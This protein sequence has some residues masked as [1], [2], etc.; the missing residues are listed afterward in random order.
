MRTLPT[1]LIAFIAIAYVSILFFIAFRGDKKNTSGFFARHR[2]VV[3]SLSLA[4]YCSSWTFFGAVGSA[5]RSGWDFFAIYLGPILVFVLGYKIIQRIIII[6]KQY[7]ITAISD[8]LS[9]RYGKSRS[10]AVLVTFIAVIGSLPYISLQLHAISMSFTTLTTPAN[11]A[12][13]YRTAD[14]LWSDTAFYGALILALFSILFGT[15]HLSAT[16][17]HRGMMNAIAFESIVKLVAMLLVGLYATQLLFSQFDWNQIMRQPFELT[18]VTTESSRFSLSDFATKLLLSMSAIMLLPRQFQVTVVE[19]EDHRQMDSARWL[20]PLYL[21]LIS[22]VVVPIALA[23]LMLLPSGSN[24]DF[25][26]LSLPQQ[27]SEFSLAM[28]AFVGGISAG[29]GMVIVASISLSTMVCNDVVMPLLIRS[30]FID[31]QQR[32]DLSQI[33]LRIRR[34]TIVLLML[35]S[36]GYFRLSGNNQQL[37]NMGLLSFAAI[38]Q[39]APAMIAALYWQRANQRGVLLGLGIGFIAWAYTLLMPNFVSPATLDAAFPNINWLHPHHLFNIQFS[40]SL[41]HGVVWS[42]LLNT[43][44]MVFGS[45]RYAPSMLDKI[46]ASIFTHTYVEPEALGQTANFAVNATVANAKILCVSIIG[47]ASTDQLFD[48]YARQRNKELKDYDIVDK[49][50]IEAIERA[51]AGVIGASSARHIITTQLLGEDVSAEDLFVMMDETSQAL[52]F[53]QDI[54]QASFENISQGISVVDKNLKLV[55]WN[56]R[57]QAMFEYPD[58]LLKIGTPIEKLIGYNAERGDCGPGEIKALIERRLKH[59]RNSGGYSSERKRRGAYIKINGNPIPGGGFVTSFTDITE[60]KNI[61]QALR[62]S[63]SRIRLYTDNLPLMLCYIGRDEKVH[64]SNKAYNQFIGKTHSEIQN[65]SVHALFDH[66]QFKD[67]EGHI[68]YALE[69]NLTEFHCSRE[70][71]EGQIT[72]YQVNYIPQISGQGEADGF[73][74]IYQ[75]I[76]QSVEASDLLKK[77]NEQLEDRVTERT[78]DLEHLNRQL[79]SLTRSKTRFLAAASHDLLQP[80]N[81]ARLFTNSLIDQPDSQNQRDVNLLHKIDSSLVGADKLLRALLDI[82]RLDTGTLSPEISHFAIADLMEDLRTELAPLAARKGLA[83]KFRFSSALVSSDKTLLRSIIQNLVSNAIRYTSSGRI[84]IACRTKGNRLQIQVF[85]T[86]TGIS[87]E[88]LPFIFDEFHR[89]Q[90]PADS[91]K[92]GLGLGLAITKRLAEI[93]EHPLSVQSAV[94]RG[95]QFSVTLP[96]YFG[97]LHATPKSKTWQ[98]AGNLAGVTVLYLEN[99]PDS[100]DAMSA[101][102]NNWGCEVIECATFEQAVKAIRQEPLAIDM[103]LADY[104][105]DES[106]TGLDFLNFA[107]EFDDDITGVLVTAEQDLAIKNAAIDNGHIFLAKPVEP[108]ALRG[109][110]TRLA[111]MRKFRSVKA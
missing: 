57:Y 108:A 35:S 42:L 78:H 88:N 85:D 77:T 70:N 98:P 59:L 4:V 17:H 7:S 94:G 66:I 60:Q 65:V 86:G 3:Y 62:N 32:P 84:L 9:S 21:L 20:L 87:E 72:Y 15:R 36:Y 93:L 99:S 50:L 103:I 47:H 69:G 33:I 46:Q 63:E 90:N 29:T 37:A 100:L 95:S 51:I 54:L 48:R 28:I 44:A 61:E 82:S 23:G 81:A 92:Q 89:I 53:N 19:A 38:I 111:S 6:S 76:T 68:Q 25:F 75:D 14:S 5:A 8:F 18:S 73:F 106:Q 104:R 16:E 102:L 80:I 41:T 97:T 49:N 13:Y 45:L 83:I 56:T 39:F 107:S 1:E 22:L 30:K 105:L 71:D 11:S 91:E 2:T 64:F 26:V 110:L 43:A 96:R 10:I 67:R 74:A 34:I 58:E 109:I 79:K 24:A 12:D 52:Q 27:N 101:L 31:I 40:S 55:A